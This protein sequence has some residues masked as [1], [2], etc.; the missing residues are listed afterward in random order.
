MKCGWFV[1]LQQPRGWRVS[2]GL[3]ADGHFL[4][5]WQVPSWNR[6]GSVEVAAFKVFGQVPIDTSFVRRD[7]RLAVG[8]LPNFLNDPLAADL[9]VLHSRLGLAVALD[10]AA[11]HTSI[12]EAVSA[13]IHVTDAKSPCRCRGRD[14]HWILKSDFAGWALTQ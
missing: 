8:R 4:C 14:W 7:A 3:A 1:R 10:M 6:R 2:G 9:G 12:C 11:L 5:G 13:Q